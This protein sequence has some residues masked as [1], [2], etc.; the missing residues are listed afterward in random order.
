M[1]VC[2]WFLSLIAL[3]ASLIGG[4]VWTATT[5]NS[6]LEWMQP[7]NSAVELAQEPPA[8][9]WLIYRYTSLAFRLPVQSQTETTASLLQRIRDIL[10]TGPQSAST[11]AQFRN[12]TKLTRMYGEPVTD[13]YK[14]VPMHDRRLFALAEHELWMFPAFKLGDVVRVRTS[15]SRQIR[16]KTVSVAP[17][18]FELDG[19]LADDECEHMIARAK[20]EQLV[21]S[22]VGAEVKLGSKSQQRTSQQAWVG[23]GQNNDDEVFRRVR[24]RVIDVAKL[25]LELAED[26]QIVYYRPGTHYYSHHDYSER[27][28]AN[29]YYAAGGN[30]LLTVLYYLNDVNEGGE[31]RFPFGNSSLAADQVRFTYGDHVVGRHVCGDDAPG[32]RIRPKRGR[33][34]MFYNLLEEKQQ[35]GIGDP[36]SLHVG[37]DPLDGAEKWLTNQWVR[38]KRVWVDGKWHL[39]DA[40]W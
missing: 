9:E 25:R 33:A 30:R 37:C 5:D 8:D 21:D 28:D 23:P 36:L 35:E 27:Y 20:R 4:Y 7:S 31:T 13:L 34:V 15:D 26:T 40:N 16:V 32:L 11:A 18:V 39:Y 10:H 29:P 3:I 12:V 38:N 2:W 14:D 17:R 24:Q 22:T 19:F 6:V 1:S